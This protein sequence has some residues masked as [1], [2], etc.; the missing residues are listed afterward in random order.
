MIDRNARA[1]RPIPSRYRRAFGSCGPSSLSQSPA[2][3]ARAAPR[4]VAGR[5]AEHGAGETARE[6]TLNASC[7]L[8]QSQSA[9]LPKGSSTACRVCRRHHA[10]TAKSN[11]TRN[12]ALT[13]T[14]RRRGVEQGGV[15]N[16]LDGEPKSR[17]AE[18]RGHA[19]TLR[20]LARQ[21]RFPDGRSRL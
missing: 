11:A 3:T 21:T 9:A 8:I 12:H 7:A 6:T 20:A 13:I 10:K 4:A 1:G 14:L 16:M 17:V 2:T 15:G 18:Y 5:R 19:E